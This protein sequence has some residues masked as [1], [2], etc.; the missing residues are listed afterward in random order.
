M[1]RMRNLVSTIF[2]TLLFIPIFGCREDLYEFEKFV[3][4]DPA[5]ALEQDDIYYLAANF[6]LPSILQTQNPSNSATDI[7]DA[8]FTWQGSHMKLSPNVQD[9]S[10]P[11]RWNQVIP[12][13]YPAEDLIRNRHF[14]EESVDKIYGVCWDFATIFTAIARYHHLD[15]RISAWQV[16]LSDRVDLQE[17][18][19]VPNLNDGADRG[20]SP[21]E[22]E[23]LV[24]RLRLLGYDIPEQ[25]LQEAIF[26]TY[27]HYRP[28]V[29]IDDTWVSYD[30]THPNETYQNAPYHEIVWNHFL[31]EDLCSDP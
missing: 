26:E 25:L 5:R 18:Y 23:A 7:A 15:V 1:I 2:L 3:A 20:M 10:Y 30:A 29:L 4:S 28:E 11:M 9:L 6:S 31:D 13:I 24:A 27:V 12:G 8:I 19:D 16:Y 22:S 14:S 17:E 21:D